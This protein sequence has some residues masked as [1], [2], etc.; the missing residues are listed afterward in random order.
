MD[1]ADLS[2]LELQMQIGVSEELTASVLSIVQSLSPSLTL[3]PVYNLLLLE[4]YEETIPLINLV[5]ETKLDI[6]Y[7]TSLQK[8]RFWIQRKCAPAIALNIPRAERKEILKTSLKDPATAVVNEMVLSVLKDNP[9]T[10]FE[11]IE[12]TRILYESPYMS[13]KIL[14]IDLLALTK[15]ENPMLDEAL[16]GNCWRIR[17]RCARILN[18][19]NIETQMKIISELKNDHIDEVRMELANNLHSLDF[20]DYLK[21]PCD[22]VRSNYLLNVANLI[23]EKS[24]FT[25]LISDSSW[26]VR[27]VLLNLRGDLFQSITIP[28]IQTSV[29]NVPWR[30][31]IEVLELIEA[32]IG[33]GSI[34]KLL[35]VFLIKNIKDKICVIRDKAADVFLKVLDKYPWTIE[36][37]WDI[38]QIAGSANYLH[39][40]SV[41]PIAVAFDRK[42]NTNIS[43]ILRNDKIVNVRECYIECV[44]L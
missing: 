20:I 2:I 21:D 10:D 11:L 1:Q 18:K 34:A 37:A 13:N 22:F 43:E 42:Y 30:T 31:K 33:D 32:Q 27:K 35:V 39:R 24:V 12:I 6:E 25:E 40:I 23:E 36:Y 9:F 5:M 3:L 26:E 15:T 17:L 14:S 44:P 8:S 16:R 7:I 29:E 4:R 28:L 19:F 41:V 38:E